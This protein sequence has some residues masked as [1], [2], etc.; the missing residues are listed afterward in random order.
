MTGNC[1]ICKLPEKDVIHDPSLCKWRKQ[2]IYE[3][4]QKMMESTPDEV[5]QE[6]LNSGYTQDE[7]DAMG[8]RFQAVAR[9]ASEESPLNPKN[10]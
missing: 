4:E 5:N 8:V 1:P 10:R 2:A 7:I 6:L 9:K 3:Y